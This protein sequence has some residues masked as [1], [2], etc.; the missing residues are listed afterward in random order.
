MAEA[1]SPRDRL[2]IV[3]DVVDK[4]GLSRFDVAV[5]QWARQD[6]KVKRVWRAEMKKRIAHIRGFFAELGF[7]GD[8]LEMRT[9]TFVAYQTSERDLFDDL[10]V[11]DR[12]KI[13]G[14]QI[15]L[16]T[17]GVD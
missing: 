2:R 16:L 8:D 4:A 7:E 5:R 9:R 17:Q 6:P 14:L 12:E 1:A 3:A 11:R 15:A 10:S 13:R